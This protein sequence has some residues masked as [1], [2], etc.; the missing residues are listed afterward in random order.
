Q[1]MGVNHPC[2]KSRPLRNSFSP[3]LLLLPPAQSICFAGRLLFCP[4]RL[5]FARLLTWIPAC[6]RLIT[7]HR[8]MRSIGPFKR[9]PLLLPPR[10]GAWCLMLKANR[11]QHRKRW[12]SFAALIGDRFIASFGDRVSG[13]TR[14]KILPKGFFRCC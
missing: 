1:A 10:I 14:R 12:R 11:Q 8:G 5:A 2:H 7:G 3:I 13:L 6:Q 9:T 4:F